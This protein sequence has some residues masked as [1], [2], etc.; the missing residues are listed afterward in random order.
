MANVIYTAGDK[1]KAESQLRKAV[2]GYESQAS[3]NGFCSNHP[4][5]ITMLINLSQICAEQGQQDEA[6]NFLKKAKDLRSSEG[7]NL[8]L[9]DARLCLA[10]AYLYWKCS[11]VEAALLSVK[12]GSVILNEIG[13]NDHPY[14]ARAMILTS[15]LRSEQANNEDF[16]E[17]V[18]CLNSAQAVLSHKFKAIP[19]ITQCNILEL[20][21]DLATDNH[22]KKECLQEASNILKE[23]TQREKRRSKEE[24][25]V[26]LPILQTWIKKSNDISDKLKLF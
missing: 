4:L 8:T 18:K 16:K 12:N 10:N 20:Q 22:Y 25:Y 17:A 14:Y 1:E 19:T 6:I 13:Y 15:Q 2:Q 9:L 5:F 7:M 26:Y 11:D 23:I 21:A 3:A 24:V